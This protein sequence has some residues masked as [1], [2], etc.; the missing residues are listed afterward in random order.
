MQM[1]FDQVNR[2][3]DPVLGPNLFAQL[4]RVSASFTSG[5]A[6]MVSSRSSVKGET[7]MTALGGLMVE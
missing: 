2:R 5:M 6:R 1:L 4:R 7:P 3:P